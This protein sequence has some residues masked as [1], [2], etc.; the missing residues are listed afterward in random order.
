MAPKKRIIVVYKEPPTH[1]Y[2]K[3]CL[4]LDQRLDDHVNEIWLMMIAEHPELA[5]GSKTGHQDVQ[6]GSG[7]SNPP[8]G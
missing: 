7:A 1:D 3:D 4:L 2:D 6:E 5:N 8:P